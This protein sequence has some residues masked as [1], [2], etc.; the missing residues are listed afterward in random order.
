MMSEIQEVTSLEDKVTIAPS[1]LLTVVR[2][3]TLSVEGVARMGNMPGGVDR[4]FRRNPAANGVMIVVDGEAQTVVCDLYIVVKPDVNM[5]EVSYNVQ[6]KVTRAIHE[7]V[8]M[9]VL[10]INVHIED[11]AYDTHS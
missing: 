7:I 9:D 8:G 4:I 3:T 11:I 6:Q 10:A 5:Q 1:V 2:Y